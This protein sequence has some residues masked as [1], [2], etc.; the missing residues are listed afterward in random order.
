MSPTVRVTPQDLL[1]VVDVQNDFC[2]GG[3]LPVPDGDAVVPVINR[4]MPRFPNVAL[5]QDWHPRGH[6][7]FASSHKGMVP[8]QSMQLPYGTQILWPDHCVPGTRGAEFHPDLKLE[9]AQVI[10]R[11]GF[12]PQLDSYSALFENDRTS[13]TG[14]GG[15][16]EERGIRRLFIA[17]LALAFCVQ[18]SALDARRL[19]FAVL[20]VEDAVRGIDVDDSIRE[21]WRKMGAARIRRIRERDLS[22]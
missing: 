7:S 20:V 19:G 16:L 4:L 18:Y 14:L 15:Y 5:T 12:N 21:A 8:L 1:L 3:A 11:K 9:S 17:G 13:P 2:P 10:V 6:V 22:P